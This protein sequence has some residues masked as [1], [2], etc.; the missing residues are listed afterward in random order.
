M[1]FARLNTIAA[2]AAALL[3]G[4]AQAQPGSSGF[5]G[6]KRLTKF[7]GHVVWQPRAVVANGNR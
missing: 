1:S 7:L 2:L 6:L 4:H 5:V 3:A